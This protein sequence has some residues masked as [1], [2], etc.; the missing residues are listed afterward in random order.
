MDRKAGALLDLSRTD[1]TSKVKG[2]VQ[3]RDVD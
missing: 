2:Y 3:D 1:I